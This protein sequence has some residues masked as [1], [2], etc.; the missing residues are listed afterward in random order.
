MTC[1]EA[2]SPCGRTWLAPSLLGAGPLSWALLSPLS[3][4]VTPLFP[5]CR[6]RPHVCL[7]PRPSSEP[8]AL[9]GCRWSH[10]GA[11]TNENALAT[12]MSH[13]LAVL[14]WTHLLP[15][16]E[17]RTHV[18]KSWEP[19][20][21]PHFYRRPWS[22]PPSSSPHLHPAPFHSRNFQVILHSAATGIF[23]NIDW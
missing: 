8:Q 13:V 14:R 16:P 22:E 1:C 12:L 9:E 17:P 2:L 23:Q 18:A 15:E 19:I 21:L 20:R 10:P 6:P 11:P 3:R 7:W 4:P 5:S